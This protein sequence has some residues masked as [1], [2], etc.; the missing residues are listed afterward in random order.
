MNKK[1]LYK[2]TL[3][4]MLKKCTMMLILLSMFLQWNSSSTILLSTSYGADDDDAPPSEPPPPIPVQ[5]VQIERRAPDW[6]QYV[7]PATGNKYYHDKTTNRT[8]WNAPA[9]FTDAKTKIRYYNNQP[10]PTTPTRSKTPARTPTPVAAN[11]KRDTKYT[12]NLWAIHGL[13]NKLEKAEAKGDTREIS[14]LKNKIKTEE[15]ILRSIQE[16][17]DAEL[18]RTR[19]E[20]YVTESTRR[21]SPADVPDDDAVSR[22]PSAPVSFDQELAMAVE[23]RRQ[24]L[25]AA[26][27]LEQ[28]PPTRSKVVPTDTN[29]PSVLRPPPPLLSTMPDGAAPPPTIPPSQTTTEER[30]RTLESKSY[31]D[32]TAEDDLELGRLRDLRRLS[33]SGVSASASTSPRAPVPSSVASST[34]SG[35]TSESAILQSSPNEQERRS[36]LGKIEQQRNPTATSQ[37]QGVAP[38]LDQN[39]LARQYYEAQGRALGSGSP[40]ASA[41]DFATMNRIK[42]QF[43]GKAPPIPPTRPISTVGSQQELP[44]APRMLSEVVPADAPPTTPLKVPTVTSPLPGAPPLLSTI[45]EGAPVP[46]TTRPMDNSPAEE[47]VE[48][49]RHAITQEQEA[50]ILQSSPKE[51]ELRRKL[52]IAEYKQRNRAAASSAATATP[53]TAPPATSAID[54]EGFNVNRNTLARSADSTARTAATATPNTAPPATSAIDNPPTT[55]TQE[56]TIQLNEHEQLIVRPLSAGAGSSEGEYEYVRVFSTSTGAQRESTISRN[57]AMEKITTANDN[58]LA[59]NLN[60]SSSAKPKPIIAPLR[61]IEESLQTPT[62]RTTQSPRAASASAAAAAA[63]GPTWQA[64]MIEDNDTGVKRFSRNNQNQIL[65][66]DGTSGSIKPAIEG[67]PDAKGR[68]PLYVDDQKT[69]LT[70]SNGVRLYRDNQG[71]V[72]SYKADIRSSAR[73]ADQNDDNTQ[74]GVGGRRGTTTAES[75]ATTQRRQSTTP[76]AGGETEDSLGASTRRGTTTVATDT[77]DTESTATTQRRQST[78]PAADGET[79]NSYGKKLGGSLSVSLFAGMG[80]AIGQLIKRIIL[81]EQEKNI[82]AN[83]KALK[84]TETDMIPTVNCPVSGMYCKEGEESCN[85]TVHW[86]IEGYKVVFPFIITF[87]RPLIMSPNPPS[88]SGPWGRFFF[89]L[90]NWAV[91]AFALDTTYSAYVETENRNGKLEELIKTMKSANKKT[92]TLNNHDEDT[93][94]EI[95]AATQELLANIKQKIDRYT[96]VLGQQQIELIMANAVANTPA[97]SRSGK[98]TPKKI[99]IDKALKYD[100][101]C[102][103]ALNNTCHKIDIDSLPPSIKKHA[104]ILQV[105]NLLNRVAEGKIHPTDLDPKYMMKT[106]K[107]IASLTAKIQHSL[108]ETVAKSGNPNAI[109]NLNKIKGK[110]GVENALQQLIGIAK[111]PQLQ[112]LAKIFSEAKSL[113]AATK[114]THFDISK[115]NMS[116]SM[117]TDMNMNMEKINYPLMTGGTASKEDT[118]KLAQSRVIAA[119]K[120][121]PKTDSGKSVEEILRT[122]KYKVKSIETR[123][124][125]NIWEMISG[126][127]KKKEAL[128]GV[129]P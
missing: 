8:T 123:P 60:K 43:G 73:V 21:T 92:M 82:T 118:N 54:N 97:S 74:E 69:P 27:P 94:K 49:T 115:M 2:F 41:A 62:P 32:R 13:R 114:G 80:L 116:M 9:I 7:D 28:S 103:C 51:L 12:I 111:N 45:P 58:I 37:R 121:I 33:T 35:T 6:V 40:E 70:D 4:F 53:N 129:N 38:T 104:E 47:R 105:V 102:A 71:T 77:S 85:A 88:A 76:A 126:R 20:D 101:K 107:K 31:L 67:A 64:T 93:P 108:P 24:K 124:E 11:R 57:D 100:T 14:R 81:C 96:K 128:W 25:E 19:P 110:I 112:Q 79:E 22:R 36:I 50:A 99:C 119:E 1:Y 83:A 39:E 65:I 127:Y 48:N 120:N 98:I 34:A 23:K 3:N 106:A 95:H 75:T 66:N 42:T 113:S 90:L 5:P 91:D 15:G 72:V 86:A 89:S 78:I 56:R 84:S 55:P 68:I 52:I 87:M 63:K 30:I 61:M 117:S 16:S 59:E 26:A 46:Q 17:D 44:P 109:K 125:I 29:P 18:R 122:E 10:P